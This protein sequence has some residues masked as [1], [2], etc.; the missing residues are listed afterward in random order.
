MNDVEKKLEN[1]QKLHCP[2]VHHITVIMLLQGH[3]IYTRNQDLTPHTSHLTPHTSHLTPHL[4]MEN[5]TWK[6]RWK[7]KY[8]GNKINELD[9]PPAGVI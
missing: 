2:N 9:S 6:I 4:S 1:D 3:F 8:D 7:N 5:P